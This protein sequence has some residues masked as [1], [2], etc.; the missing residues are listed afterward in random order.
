MA[1]RYLRTSEIAEAVG[2]H[3]NTVRLY[4][5]W[6]YLPPIPRSRTGYRRFTPRHLEQMRLAR[7]ALQW[8]YP[9]G[10]AIIVDLIKSAAEGNL[11]QA[12]ELAFQ[13]LA[14]V[15]AERAHAEAAVA[16][17]ERWAQGGRADTA[18]RP[19]TIGATAKHLALSVDML[20]N[21]ERNGLLVTPRHPQS[22]YRLYGAPEIGRLRVIRMLRQ[23]GY[24]MMAILR[25]L[26]RFDAG[27]R[28]NLRLVLDT[29]ALDEDIYYV[30]DNWLT[31]L[32]QTEAR[33]QAV[34]DQINTMLEMGYGGEQ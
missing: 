23:A 11:G 34:I 13:F 7:I 4:E 20:R 30:S 6:G 8:P 3:P 10:K 26:R 19:L 1:T 28:Q 14:Q 9:G 22:G 24:S 27:E 15:Q 31:T 17:L 2:V 29:P 16:F 12:L 5:A 21:W 32:A 33:A 25:M 18:A